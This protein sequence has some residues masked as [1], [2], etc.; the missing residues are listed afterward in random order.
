MQRLKEI[1]DILN[2][3]SF[4][5]QEKPHLMKK[6]Y[7]FESIKSVNSK[8]VLATDTRRFVF[9]ETELDYFMESIE[10]IEQSIESK[11]IKKEENLHTTEIVKNVTYEVPEVC[12]LLSHGMLKL[13]DAVSSGNASDAEINAAKHASLL[14]SKLIDVEKIKLGYLILN[15]K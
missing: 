7:V 15:N 13:F 3:K 10:I 14:A 5:Y 8:I 9:T 6:T 1:E 2:G 4:E 11:I 12:D